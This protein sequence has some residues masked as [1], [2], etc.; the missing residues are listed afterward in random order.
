MSVQEG[1]PIG[2]AASTADSLIWIFGRAILETSY[3]VCAILLRLAARNERLI[4][5][6]LLMRIHFRRARDLACCLA[7]P[8]VR[9]FAGTERWGLRHS[10]REAMRA[11]S[12]APCIFVAH[13]RRSNSAEI[14]PSTGACTTRFRAA[15]RHIRV[16]RCRSDHH[17]VLEYDSFGG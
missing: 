17:N 8:A 9:I 4:Q 3:S 14:H 5:R 16:T 15:L 11:P 7:A 12:R 1:L 6:P 10:S 2:L 13:P